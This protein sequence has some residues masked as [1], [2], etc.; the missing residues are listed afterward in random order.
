MIIPIERVYP[1]DKI[2]FD[3]NPETIS[4]MFEYHEIEILKESGATK[5]SL[6][7]E[8]PIEFSAETNPKEIDWIF[9]HKDPVIKGNFIFWTQVD[10]VEVDASDFVPKLEIG[11]LENN[12]C[13]ISH[14]HCDLS[15]MIMEIYLGEI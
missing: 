14:I 3:W 15:R 10:Q 12:E 9:R 4:G 2:E 5:G 6:N 8:F 11:E 1:V 13:K 7:I